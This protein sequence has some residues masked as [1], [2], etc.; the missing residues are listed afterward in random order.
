MRLMLMLTRLIAGSDMKRSA[1]KTTAMK[2][3]RRAARLSWSFRSPK[4]IAPAGHDCA[5]AGWMS[6]SFNSR[7]SALAVALKVAGEDIARVAGFLASSEAG[8]LT[9]EKLV[10]S[11][12]FP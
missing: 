2:T 5:H 6:P 12:G 7:S 4:T 1:R 10:A 3:L 8:W 11:G 9:G